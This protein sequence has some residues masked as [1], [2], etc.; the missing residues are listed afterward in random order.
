MEEKKSIIIYNGNQIELFSDALDNPF[1]NITAAAKAS[2]NRKSILT[3]IRTRQT[4]EFLNVWEK[5]HNPNYV[6]AQLS[7]VYKLI[8]ER[9][10]SIKNWVELTNAK[11]IYTRIG[12]GLCP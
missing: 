3:W 1:L 9:N 7:T 5:K 12:E 4:I 6:G 10:F 11:G 2:G 8:K